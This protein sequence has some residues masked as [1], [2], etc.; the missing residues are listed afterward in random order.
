IAFKVKRNMTMA[1]SLSETRLGDT[2]RLEDHWAILSVIL[3][4]SADLIVAKD[5]L[6]NLYPEI[7]MVDINNFVQLYSNDS[8]YSNHQTGLHSEIHGIE[9]EEAWQIQQGEQVARVGIYD[10]GINF[11]HED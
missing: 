7:K 1:D 6:V 3:P 5:S 4:E 9:I 11:A 8:Y 2:L 10:S